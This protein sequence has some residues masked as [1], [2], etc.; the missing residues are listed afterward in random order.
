MWN[1]LFGIYLRC[2]TGRTVGLDKA[3]LEIYAMV[4]GIYYNLP[5]NYT[6]QLWE[7][8]VKSID[9]TNVVCGI[10]CA[11][12]WSLILKYA[13]EKKGIVVPTD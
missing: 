3:K 2:L 11:R 10:S 5:V 4:A 9:N 13:Y 1:F 6:T 8:F 7:E 12:Y